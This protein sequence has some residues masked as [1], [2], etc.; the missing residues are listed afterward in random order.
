LI[1]NAWLI[2]TL[3]QQPKFV[4]MSIQ[5]RSIDPADNAALANIIRDV[6]IE[7]K[8]PLTGT[9]YDDPRTDRLYEVF[10]EERSAYFVA[11]LEGTLL[12]GCGVYPTEGLP[13][14]CGEL[15][16]F[17]LSAASRGKG[18]GRLLMEQTFAVA[19]NLGY[20]QLYLETFPQLATAVSL[21]RKAG[22]YD[23]DKPRGNSGHYAT[24]V[25]MLKDL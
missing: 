11:E 9:V 22:F 25:W 13:E 12:G 18:L 19:Q 15:V 4:C 1:N 3:I 23:I 6:F 20:R 17:Y 8:A 7:F 14:G 24:S 2:D 10:Q 16:K 21:Y 5:I